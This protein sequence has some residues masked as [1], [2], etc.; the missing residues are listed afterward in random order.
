MEEKGKSERTKRRMEDWRGLL[1]NYFGEFVLEKLANLR[2]GFRN[3]WEEES[4]SGL[5]QYL[6]S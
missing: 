5:K 4:V 1:N 3:P 6:P 2:R